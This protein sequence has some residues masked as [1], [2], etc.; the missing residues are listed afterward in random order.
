MIREQLLEEI[1]GVVRSLDQLRETIV[2]V[3]QEDAVR[4]FQ[5][6][7]EGQSLNRL[8]NFAFQLLMRAR[9][10]LASP[11]DREVRVSVEGLRG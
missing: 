8:G 1:L 11:F 10:R 5:V 9:S 7:R 3:D 6:P 4:Q 2:T